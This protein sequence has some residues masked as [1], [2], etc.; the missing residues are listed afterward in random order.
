MGKNVRG[1]HHVAIHAA[2]F[3]RTV[4]FYEKSLEF[5]PVLSW[6]TV[7]KRALMLDV[8]NGS[9]IEVFENG[10][11]DQPE[12]AWCHLALDVTDCDAVFEAAIAAGCT[13]Q[14]A[15]AD[16]V[17]HGNVETPVRI[18]FVRGFNGEI[19]EFFQTK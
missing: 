14:S 13:V 16:V 6:G 7:G 2:D 1:L 9:R 8:G 19:F 4:E 15:P 10:S 11:P 3:D 5:T 18:A 12:G 17:I